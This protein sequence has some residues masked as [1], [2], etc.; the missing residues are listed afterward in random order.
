MKEQDKTPKQWISI[1]VKPEEYNQVYRFYSATTCKK[2]SQY[3]R[4]VLLQKPVTVN[5]RNQ[6]ADDFLKEVIQLKNELHGIANN[7]NQ[8]VKR[9]HTLHTIPEIKTWA[10]LNEAMQK[11]LMAKIEE[12]RLYMSQL[13]QQWLQK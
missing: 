3:V 11:T 7:F 13:H 2:L 4:K 5:Y 10:V 6:S 12:I 8:S 1:R 9:L